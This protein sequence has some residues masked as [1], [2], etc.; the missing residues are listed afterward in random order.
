MSVV[1]SEVAILSLF[2]LLLYINSQ[3]LHE[4]KSTHSHVA[5]FL[6]CNRSAWVYIAQ[7]AGGA[8]H[9]LGFPKPGPDKWLKVLAGAESPRSV[10][11]SRVL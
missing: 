1:P 7:T 8:L 6:C 10:T 4:S 5:K 3:H 2:Y 11:D 9:A